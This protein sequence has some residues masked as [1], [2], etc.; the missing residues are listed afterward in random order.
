[1]NS[2][3]LAARCAVLE[4]ALLELFAELR[5]SKQIT[6]AQGLAALSRANERASGIEEQLEAAALRERMAPKP[7]TA[8]DLNTM[9]AQQAAT[10]QLVLMMMR[11]LA[12]LTSRAGECPEALADAWDQVGCRGLER[13]PFLVAPGSE[14]EVIDDAKVRLAS[15]IDVGLRKKDPLT[16]AG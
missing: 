5:G 10:T 15:L 1:M 6:E 3:V 7:L 8:A 11:R 12:T 9:I 2:E 14:Q 4:R 16:P 13:T